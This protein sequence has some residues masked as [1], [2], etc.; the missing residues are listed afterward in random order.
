MVWWSL[1]PNLCSVE[2]QENFAEIYC[3]VNSN[4]NSLETEETLT[5]YLGIKDKKWQWDLSFLTDITKVWMRGTEALSE[6]E[7]ATLVTQLEKYK[8]LH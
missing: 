7:K 4:S 8:G 6:R 3:T 5:K 1:Y 2:S